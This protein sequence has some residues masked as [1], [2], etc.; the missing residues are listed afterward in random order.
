MGFGSRVLCPTTPRPSAASVSRA[1]QG[2]AA[3]AAGAW[4]TLGQWVRSVYL[5]MALSATIS[6][7]PSTVLPN[8]TFRVSL[9]ISNP[10]PSAVNILSVLPT[11][12]VTGPNVDSDSD[13][14]GAVLTPG[15]SML[16]AG[17]SLSLAWQSV[18]YVPQSGSGS[19]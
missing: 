8:Q 1:P 16:A 13:A 9:V 19:A 2:T 18:V 12:A 7:A 4:A 10:G 5:A 15:N 14:N 11:M 3:S 17:G 6:V